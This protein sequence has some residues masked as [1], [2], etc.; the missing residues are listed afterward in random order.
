MI[1][2]QTVYERDEWYKVVRAVL[3]GSF[4]ANGKD[5]VKTADYVLE[6]DRKRV[7]KLQAAEEGV[8]YGR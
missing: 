7:A 2:F 4:L 1:E 5:A 3:K 8:N 6:Q